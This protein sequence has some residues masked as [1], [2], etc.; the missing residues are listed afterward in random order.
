MPFCWFCN[1]AAQ[2]KALPDLK[3]T[4]L[5]MYSKHLKN[6]DTQK[7]AVIILTFEHC[8]FTI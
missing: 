1:E 4:S 2:I 6:S 5:Q 8:D 7:I 3:R